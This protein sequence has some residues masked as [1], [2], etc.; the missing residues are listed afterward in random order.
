M[1]C[2]WIIPFLFVQKYFLSC[3]FPVNS[4]KSVLLLCTFQRC[5]HLCCTS[6]NHFLLLDAPSSDSIRR[7][8]H[9]LHSCTYPLQLLSSVRYG[10][11]LCPVTMDRPY[12]TLLIQFV[13][14]FVAA[15]SQ[16]N[17]NNPLDLIVITPNSSQ[18]SGA[19][20]PDTYDE[21]FE[22][23][24]LPAGGGPNCQCV[25]YYLC[26]PDSTINTNGEGGLIDPR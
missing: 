3:S 10:S 18:T 9:N 12:T 15:M 1:K 19:T 5:S 17:D 2:A 22:P 24:L 25:E 8:L 16:M 20:Q 14:L 4:N 7:T 21:V 26:N 6:P 13:L 11:A 23:E